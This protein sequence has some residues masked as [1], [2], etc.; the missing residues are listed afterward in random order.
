MEDPGL[1]FT[2][3][4]APASGMF[5]RVEDDLR[6][7]ERR[8]NLINFKNNFFFG[9]LRG[10]GII[11]VVIDDKDPSRGLGIISFEKICRDYGRIR[12]VAEGPDGA[13]YFSTSNRD[14]RRTV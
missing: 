7:A 10:E 8:G 4:E 9:C 2:P 3:A 1:E 14:G 6:G 13:I 11:R 5:Y 12:D